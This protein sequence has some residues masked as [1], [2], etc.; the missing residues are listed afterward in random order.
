VFGLGK[1]F[2]L[3]SRF[4]K[5]IDYILGL[6]SFKPKSKLK[7]KYKRPETDDEFRARRSNDNKELDKILDKLK[8]SGYDSLSPNEKRFLF[9]ASRK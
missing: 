4:N 5:I 8:K 2:D 3:T 6:F 1:G 9:D 7:V